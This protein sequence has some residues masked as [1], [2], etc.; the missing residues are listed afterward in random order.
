MVYHLNQKWKLIIVGCGVIG[1]LFGLGFFVPI[2][3]SNQTARDAMLLLIVGLFFLLMGAELVYE[4]TKTKIEIFEDEII[5]H[6]SRYTFSARWKNLQRI[7]PS[8]GLLVLMFSDPK[9]INCGA[10]YKILKSLNMHSGLAINYYLTKNNKEFIKEKIITAT[11]LSDKNDIAL[12]DQ[13]LQP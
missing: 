13:I 10:I 7:A 8:Y 6:Q 9:E 11:N 2:F 12:L 1:C 4:G 3:F 5:Y